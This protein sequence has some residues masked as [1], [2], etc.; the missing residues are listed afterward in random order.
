VSALTTVYLGLGSNLGDRKRNLID[1]IER[2]APDV[3]VESVSSLY[4]TDPVGPPGQQDYYNAVCRAATQLEPQELLARV[5]QIERDMGRTEGAR[6]GPRD[7]DIDILLYGERQVMEEGLEIPH[8]EMTKRG[9][10]LV[11]LA[12]L[13]AD[14]M[15]PTTGRTIGDLVADVDAAGVRFLEERGW[16]T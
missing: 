6:W 15:H 5:K 8:R 1:A 7:I 2:L 9:F 14:V 4:E 13:A 16:E 12:E 11:P 10:V 3:R